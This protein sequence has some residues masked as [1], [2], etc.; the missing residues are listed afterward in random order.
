M[1]CYAR[2]AKNTHIDYI[3]TIRQGQ[4]GLPLQAVETYAMKLR[5]E[6]YTGHGL[7]SRLSR[8]IRQGQLG[9][10]PRAVEIYVMKLREEPYTGQGLVS[11]LSRIC[12][13]RRG[14]STLRG[15]LQGP[16]EGEHY[17]RSVNAKSVVWTHFSDSSR[18]TATAYSTT[19]DGTKLGRPTD[20]S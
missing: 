6:P 20:P 10:P 13:S 18:T 17:E 4:L 5:E 7:V 9:L 14:R 3:R 11:R 12:E 2:Y 15:P 8:T 19:F 16:L 1:L